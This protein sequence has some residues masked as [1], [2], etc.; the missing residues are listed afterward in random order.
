[1][2]TINFCTSQECYKN[3][4]P[5]WSHPYQLKFI[6]K[7]K[8]SFSFV[9]CPFLNQRKCPYV[10]RGSIKYFLLVILTHF[11]RMFL[12]YTSYGLFMF[13]GNLEKEHWPNTAQKMK[14]STMDFFSKCDQIRSFLWIWSYLLKKSL[15]E[16]LLCCV[17]WVNYHIPHIPSNI[18]SFDDFF[19]YFILLS[20]QIK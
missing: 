6:I 5:T 9:K 20:Y 11:R 3:V 12:F 10:H 2:K 18:A 4:N 8:C 17:N 15:M 14:F 19:S 16:N 7:G 13:S 1:M